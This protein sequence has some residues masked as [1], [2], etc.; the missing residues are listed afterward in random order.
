MITFQPQLN[1]SA[2]HAVPGL[3]ISDRLFLARVES[4]K[5]LTFAPN[6]LET[7]NRKRLESSRALQEIWEV[8]KDVQRLFA[9]AKQRNVPGY[10]KYIL[11]MRDGGLGITPPIMLYSEQALE[12]EVDPTYQMGF[13]IVPYGRPL[14]A[15]DG[16]TQLAARHAAY[17][18]N[19]KTG[20][21]V[22][23]V[24]IAHGYDKKWARQ[25]FH[26]LNVLGI[27]PNAAISIGMDARDPLTSIARDVESAV[28]FF[29]KRV[30]MVRRQ[31]KAS[32]TDVVTVTGLRSACVTF[33]EGIAGVRHGTKPVLVES[34]RVE[35]MRARSI[36][37]FLL[38]TSELSHAFEPRDSKMGTA[39]AVLAAIGA[40]GHVALEEDDSFRRSAEM[41]RQLH[42]LRSV[43]WNREGGHWDG[44]A[45]KTNPKGIF[46][47]GG[48]KEYGYAAFEAL[49]N[50]QST[51][52]QRIRPNDGEFKLAAGGG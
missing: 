7:E 44:I 13:A 26:D 30:N 47:V 36:E 25:A 45:G 32:D 51:G 31:L 21:D 8:R 37:W 10:S 3:K 41:Q 11:D 34:G 42:K 48:S 50:P 14:V 35:S 18:R 15:L 19:P 2:G 28:P 1:L 27:R 9:G 43:N 52:G 22:V 16:E 49:N 40:M 24:L 46:A 6:P 33:A 12:I 39:P 17:E 4:A 38:V 29:R 23:A 20:G 5:L